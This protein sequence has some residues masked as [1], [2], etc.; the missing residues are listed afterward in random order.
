MRKAAVCS[1][2]WALVACGGRAHNPE[3]A[4]PSSGGDSSSAGSDHG[5]A[6]AS[7]GGSAHGGAGGAFIGQGGRNAETGGGGGGGESSL[8]CSTPYQGPN[9][10]PRSDGPSELAH[11]ASITDA[12][13]LA[14]YK[15]PAARVPRGFYYEPNDSIAFWNEPCSASLADTVARGP[16]DGM[17]TFVE[18]YSNEW[19]HE[20][21]YCLNGVRRLERNLRCDYFDGENLAKPSVDRMAFLAGL[22]WW[23][24]NYNLSGSAILGHSVAGGNAVDIVQLCTLRTVHGDF[25]LCD[26]VQLE[27]TDYRVWLNGRVAIGE[28]QVIRTLKGDCH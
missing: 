28:T 11:C 14:R 9:S 3:F 26:E 23:T 22:L 17:G 15:D 19:F 24:K 21:V 12:D 2:L 16:T 5:D 20:A 7:V 10:S 8:A 18:S 25:G 4:Q 27:S 13:I 6:G 1:S